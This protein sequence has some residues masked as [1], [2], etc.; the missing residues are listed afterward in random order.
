MK[1][2]YFA[3]I[4]PVSVYVLAMETEQSKP[5]LVWHLDTITSTP[6]I[7]SLLLAVP[8]ELSS[9]FVKKGWLAAGSLVW[10]LTTIASIATDLGKKTPGRVNVIKQLLVA[11]KDYCTW[12]EDDKHAL[13]DF[14]VKP[15]PQQEIIDLIRTLK[16]NGIVS[17]G[18]GELDPEE[19]DIYVRKLGDHKINLYDLFIKII[20]VAARDE[21][22][23]ADLTRRSTSHP[24]SFFVSS[25]AYPEVLYLQQLSIH[26]KTPFLL[27]DAN[28]E[29][30]AAVLQY[31]PVIHC[32]SAQELK[33]EFIKRGFI[34]R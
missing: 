6:G 30:V 27:I 14:A 20:G 33:N 18:I 28:E 23:Q 22:N 5:S 26:V 7:A 12:D 31:V 3:L 16:A 4:L 34:P 17:I 8:T 11:L 15:I 19:H 21:T 2:F 1:K 32:N 29:R 25:S 24:N 10:N 13:A 9:I